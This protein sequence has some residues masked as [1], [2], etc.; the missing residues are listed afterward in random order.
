MW[1]ESVSFELE[2]HVEGNVC[3]VLRSSCKLSST[4]IPLS[5]G[6]ACFIIL[7][8]QHPHILICVGIKQHHAIPSTS[9]HVGM[10]YH[11]ITQHQHMLAGIIT[12]SISISTSSHGLTSSSLAQQ[13]STQVPEWWNDGASC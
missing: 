9:T 1:G 4:L 6:H 10:C 2:E 3:V 5:L 11:I 8:H 12:S 13:T 7:F